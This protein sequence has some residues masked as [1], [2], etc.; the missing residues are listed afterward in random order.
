V[1]DFDAQVYRVAENAGHLC[2]PGEFISLC[3]R[4][5]FRCIIIHTERERESPLDPH[6]V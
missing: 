4:G 2:A 5:N 6:S 3:F 1:K